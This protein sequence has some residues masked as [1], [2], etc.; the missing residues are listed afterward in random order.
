MSGCDETPVVA[1]FAEMWRALEAWDR[2]RSKSLEFSDCRVQFY[3][4]AMAIPMVAVQPRV[5]VMPAAGLIA[6]WQPVLDGFGLVLDC[7]TE[8]ANYKL[9]RRGSGEY[10][11]RILPDALKFHA[12]R[13]LDLGREVFE[14]ICR[15]YLAL[16]PETV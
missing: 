3:M 9:N 1:D 14:E 10:V 4:G 6:A 11:G 5:P 15:H 7:V 16:P 8:G 2:D 12:T 13:M